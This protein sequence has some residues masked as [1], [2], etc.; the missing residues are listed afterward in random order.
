MMD[1]KNGNLA[2]FD[3][4]FSSVVDGQTVQ[5]AV[6]LPSK[7]SFTYLDPYFA[8]SIAPIP[9]IL[10]STAGVPQSLSI[11]SKTDFL[12]RFGFAWRVRGSDK[13][14]LRGGYGLFVEGW[15]GGSVNAGFAL[16]SL[17]NA[18]FANYQG[19]NGL[20]VFSLPYSYPT[21]FTD[22]GSIT[23]NDSFEIK[24]KD[25]KVEQWNLTL[26]RD[27]GKGVGFRVSYVGNHSYHLPLRTL[28]KEVPPNT[29]GW[30]SPVIQAEIPFK[31]F[32]GI[33]EALNPIGTGHYNAAVVS[34]KR[35]GK[36]L[37]FEAS[38]T[39]QHDLSDGAGGLNGGAEGFNNE[40]GVFVT[41][42]F[43]PHWDYGNVSFDRRQ[44]FLGTFL[45]RLPFGKGR[46]YMN[47]DTPLNWIV[48]GWEIAGIVL[49]ETGPFLSTLCTS[50]PTGEGLY[51]QFGI[52]GPA[53]VVPGVS[54][55]RGGKTVAQWIN[56]AAFVNPPD[57]VARI[58]TS[59]EGSLVG[60]GVNAT[61]LSML[62]RFTLK[63][64]LGFQLG[65]Q[66]SNVF[67]H[68]N[69]LPPSNL[70]VGI[71]AGFGQISAINYAEGAG[72]RQIEFTARATF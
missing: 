24:A 45:Y 64:R 12:P 59:N 56:P 71:P 61:G 60:P 18:N 50:D 35:E 49:S 47:N 15:L 51:Q 42:N 39:F 40:F 67:N 41:S 5:G 30:N 65:T 19:A 57:N 14:V 34:A 11:T 36:N 21:N 70:T 66:V 23:F 26:E 48:G 22:P 20:P 33:Y 3:P 58:G 27:L 7:K 43:H 25:P 62:K 17:D 16:S 63:E 13:T 31:G 28:G 53:D 8:S 72:A 54:P 9:V 4:Y 69:F 38:Y 6:I 1:P 68:P 32:F 52:G 46:D 29:L 37:Q 44:R 10:A 55:Y 2:N